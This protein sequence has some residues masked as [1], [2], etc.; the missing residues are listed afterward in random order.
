MQVLAKSQ[1]MQTGQGIAGKQGITFHKTV[2]VPMK[3]GFVLLHNDKDFEPME[4]IL[5]L[6]IQR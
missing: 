5:G 4:R 1:E 6:R 3:H 2:Y